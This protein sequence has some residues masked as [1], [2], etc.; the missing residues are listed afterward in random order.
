MRASDDAGEICGERVAGQRAGAKHDG[1]KRGRVGNRVHDARF[2]PDAWMAAQSLRDKRREGLAV[3][4]ERAAG[5]YA[6]GVRA[7]HDE[8]AGAPKLF[9]QQTHR[10]GEGRPSHRVGAHELAERVGRLR[11]RARERLLLH[12]KD[13]DPALGQLPRRFASGEARP[14]DR[15]GRHFNAG[16]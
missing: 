2:D 10:V 15:D 8:R 16:S 12:E 5:R 14:Y 7:A 13:V 4:G 1:G 6:R 11:R 3:H 9:F